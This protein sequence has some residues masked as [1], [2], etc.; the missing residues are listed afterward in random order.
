MP[1]TEA[2]AAGIFLRQSM[3]LE[4]ILVE[5]RDEKRRIDEAIS[6]LERISADRPGRRGRPPRWLQ[7]RKQ[8]G[9]HDANGAE[10]VARESIRARVQSAL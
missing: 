8:K 7:E 4:R 6:A 10:P 2:D 1:A 5:L 3:N 9:D